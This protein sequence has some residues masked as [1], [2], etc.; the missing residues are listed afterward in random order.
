MNWRRV[1]ADTMYRIG[2]PIWDT[3]PPEPLCELV[4]GPDALPP[5]TALDI[6]CGSGTNVIYLARHGWRATGID[7]SPNAIDQARRAAHDIT[8][9]TFLVGDVTKLSTLPIEQPITLVLDMGC[10]HMLPGLAKKTYVGELAKVMTSG[11]PLV[12]WEG[13]GIKPG[14]IPAAFERDFDIEDIQPRDFHIKRNLINRRITGH[15]YQLRRRAAA[16]ADPG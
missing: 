15:W 7:F 3:P 9:A 5:G 16:A 1:F 2:R 11:T 10:Y 6:G 12:M 8:G 4:E 14:E 13:I